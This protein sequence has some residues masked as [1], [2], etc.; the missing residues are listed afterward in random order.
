[1]M[2]PNEPSIQFNG[3]AFRGGEMFRTSE[4]ALFMLLLSFDLAA[5]SVTAQLHAF[6]AGVTG[7]LI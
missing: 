2:C 1:M 6:A 3:K 4:S 5:H 7:V